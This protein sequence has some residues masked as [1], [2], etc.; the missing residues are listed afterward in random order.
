MKKDWCKK[1]QIMNLEQAKQILKEHGRPTCPCKYNNS[2]EQMIAEAVKL[3]EQQQ[4]K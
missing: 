1:K 4:K 3:L 2:N